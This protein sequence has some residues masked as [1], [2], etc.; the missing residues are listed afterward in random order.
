[1]KKILKTVII[2]I[3]VFTLSLSVVGC[4]GGNEMNQTSQSTPESSQPDSSQPDSS[5]IP[6]EKSNGV[7]IDLE[8]AYETGIINRNDLLCIAY[9]AGGITNPHY[10]IT[11]EGVFED[12]FT[13]MPAG[14]LDSETSL[15]IK[16]DIAYKY[17]T[18][19][20]N[21]IAEA[22]A[23]DF[24]LDYYGCYN[25]YYIIHYELPQSLFGKPDGDSTTDVKGRD[26]DYIFVQGEGLFYAWKEN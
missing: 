26:I 14:E 19:E 21:P 11:A 3:L 6:E 12:K 17:R 16:E 1:M 20:N 15:K 4:A 22:K 8:E 23:E 5:S 18:R 24:K 9:N 7:L 13:P 25:G 2:T 10:Y